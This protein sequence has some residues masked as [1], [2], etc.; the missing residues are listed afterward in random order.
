MLYSAQFEHVKEDTNEALFQRKALL[1]NETTPD[2]AV[3]PAVPHCDIHLEWLQKISRP[4]THAN[5]HPHTRDRAGHAIPTASHHRGCASDANTNGHANDN[6]RAA[7]HSASRHRG[8]TRYNGANDCTPHA[9]A[10][11]DNRALSAAPYTGAFHSGAVSISI[12]FLLEIG[13]SKK[14][15]GRFASFPLP[16]VLTRS[17]SRLQSQMDGT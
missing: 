1:G 15:G 17:C 7:N 16:C 14:A 12:S 9:G 8:A 5:A 3:G 6:D 13:P 2:H 4:C 11:A 10:C